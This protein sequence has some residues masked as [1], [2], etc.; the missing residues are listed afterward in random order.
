MEPLTGPETHRG[1]V[2]GEVPDY[3]GNQQGGGQSHAVV[4]DLGLAV[5][6][7][8]HLV[9]DSRVGVLEPQLICGLIYVLGVTSVNA[10]KFP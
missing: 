4:D 5:E 6:E 9:G 1:Q 7:T 2:P 10:M 8:V 3:W